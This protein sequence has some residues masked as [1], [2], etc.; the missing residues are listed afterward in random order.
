MTHTLNLSLTLDR[1]LQVSLNFYRKSTEK[2]IRNDIDRFHDYWLIISNIQKLTT[3][4]DTNIY[5]KKKYLVNFIVQ[6]Y[7]KISLFL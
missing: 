2:K 5:F 3:K 6:V 4:V 7:F 1:E